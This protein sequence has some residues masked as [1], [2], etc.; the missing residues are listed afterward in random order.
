MGRTLIII[1]LLLTL[2]SCRQNSTKELY[3]KQPTLEPLQ[4]YSNNNFDEAFFNNRYYSYKEFVKVD[5]NGKFKFVYSDGTINN[6]L[7]DTTKYYHTAEAIIRI[8]TTQ[9]YLRNCNATISNDTL[10]LVLSDN[11]FSQSFYELSATKI[12]TP[13]YFKYYQTF[14]ITDSSYRKPVFSIID[15]KLILDKQEYKKGDSIKGKIVV[16]VSAYHTWD[17]IY[18]DTV[19]VYGLIKTIV[20]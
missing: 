3:L 13:F 18:T 8:D 15:Q 2:Y 16:A 11:P 4:N 7:L 17:T 20:Q 19:K 9:F 10:N 14:S 5:S 6:D 1:S 12:K